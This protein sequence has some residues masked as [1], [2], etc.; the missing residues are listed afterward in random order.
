MTELLITLEG[1]LTSGPGDDVPVGR[2]DEIERIF[3]L[4]MQEL[5][6]L[7]IIDPS[8]SGSTA[9]GEMVMSCIVEG[10]S[11][12]EAVAAADS[13][14]RS[15]LHAA[16]VCTR[17]WTPPPKKAEFGYTTVSRGA[18]ELVDA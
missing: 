16:G 2:D 17:D 3:D 7:G 5:L 11:W 10:N 6:K 14:F 9:T 1:R 18:K 4:T 8:V 12:D 15:A 13:A